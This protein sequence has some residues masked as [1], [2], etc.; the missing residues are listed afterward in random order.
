MRAA[1]AFAVVAA[2]VTPPGST[3]PSPGPRVEF[4]P[5]PT[6]EDGRA[7]YRS[8]PY[9]LSPIVLGTDVPAGLPDVRAST[10]GACHRAMYDEWKI[11]THAR[12]WMDDAQFQAEL[13][14]PRPD[15]GDVAWMCVNCHT[16]MEAQ[17]E[18]LVVGLEDGRL[19]RPVTIPN[20]SYDAGLQLEAITCATCHVRDGFVLGPYG[21]TA[22]PHATR[23]SDHLLTHDVCTRCHQA[24]AEFPELVLSCAFSTGREF[25]S[26]PEGSEGDACQ[27]CHMPAVARPA[28]VGGPERPTRRH[29]FGGSLIPKR[30]E[31]EADV[32]PLRD[33]YP[34]GLTARFT[35]LPAAVAPGATFEVVVEYRNQHAGHRLPTGD[36][37]RFLRI[38]LAAMAGDVDLAVASARVGTKYQ[39]HPTVEKL[40]DNRLLPG[41]ARSLRIEAVAPAEGAVELL[42]RAAKFRIADEALDH[43]ELRGRYPAGRTFITER[44][45]IPVVAP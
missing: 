14:K 39:W 13:H 29:W 17:L 45:T 33:V 9:Y 28:A 36:P 21:D 18:R 5:A 35:T 19:D 3:D 32:A 22:A 8:Q 11:S 23:K 44:R 20:P 31:D 30:P 4:T 2:C 15:G 27:H 24:E 7:F 10:C 26:R 37:E 25:E 41:E 34:D 16:P 43:H 12:A 1:L 42:L 6:V 40:E 38:E